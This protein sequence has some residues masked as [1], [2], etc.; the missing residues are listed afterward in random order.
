MTIG[1]SCRSNV[2]SVVKVLSGA[3]DTSREWKQV[4]RQLRASADQARKIAKL[5]VRMEQLG[6]RAITKLKLKRGVYKTQYGTHAYVSGPKAKTAFD[7]DM[8]KRIPLGIVTE[9]W[10]RDANSMLAALGGVLNAE[11]VA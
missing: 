2:A 9:T 10:I 11:K 7:V 8:Q 3:P 5:A 1:T 6:G 4:A